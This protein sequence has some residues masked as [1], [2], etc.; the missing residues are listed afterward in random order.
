MSGLKIAV[1]GAGSTYTPEL[2]EGLILRKH[3]LPLN[4]LWLMDIDTHKNHVVGGLCE[5]MLQK[6]GTGCRVH[7][8]DDLNAALKDADFVLAQIRVG[9]LPA[10]ILDETIP[11]KYGFIGQETTGI[12]GFFKALRTVPVLLD[13]AARMQTLCPNAF[14]INFSN[15]SGIIADALL[16]HTGVRMVGLCNA[17]INMLDAVRT[18]LELSPLEID[19]VGLNHLSWI[20]SVRHDG[21][22]YLAECIDKGCG[23]TPAN[24]ASATGGFSKECLHTVGGIPSAYLEYFYNRDEKLAAMTKDEKSRGETCQTIEEELLALYQQETLVDKP[25]QL[26]QRGG[27]RYSEAAISLVD[28]IHNDIGDV[29]V[30]NTLNRGALPFMADNDCVEIACKIGKKGAEPLPLGSAVPENIQALMR[31]VKTYERMTV[32]CAM[33]GDKRTAVAALM[34]H[35]LLGDYERTKACFEEMKQAHKAFLPAFFEGKAV[36]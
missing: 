7:I 6:S 1:I 25:E 23:F 19:Y 15:P 24:I 34:L 18:K 2:V 27:H 3:S 8:T 28:S 20:T 4:E 35:P 16:N 5:R 26:N 29:H 11:L 17:P 9:R 31:V 36:E 21:K 22:E 14:M 33:T 30:V 32:E 12:G 13:I 10:R